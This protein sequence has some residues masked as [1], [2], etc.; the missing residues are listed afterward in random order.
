MEVRTRKSLTLSQ[1]QRTGSVGRAKKSLNKNQIKKVIMEYGNPVFTDSGDPRIINGHSMVREVF[2]PSRDLTISE[3]VFRVRRFYS[4]LGPLY[5]RVIADRDLIGHLIIE[6]SDLPLFD[7]GTVKA[8]FGSLLTLREGVKHFI[9]FIAPV[10]EGPGCEMTAA[11]GVVSW[12]DA[13]AE[14]TDTGIYNWRNWG[15]LGAV[16]HLELYFQ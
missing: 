11:E 3:V 13:R 12:P 7:Y 2:V 1:F 6:R 16:S 15:D 4:L 5:L 8:G 10:C 9:E 14:Y